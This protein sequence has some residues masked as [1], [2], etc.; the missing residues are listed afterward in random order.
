MLKNDPPMFH[1][2]QL[3]VSRATAAI[4][5]LAQAIEDQLEGG[6]DDDGWEPIEDLHT[7][8]LDMLLDCEAKVADIHS[9]ALECQRRIRGWI[10]RR[11]E[12][13]ESLES[14]AS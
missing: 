12:A 10:E 8:S 14:Q 6:F 1:A 4:A 5:E 7:V 3:D 13:E 9:H 2:W 11:E